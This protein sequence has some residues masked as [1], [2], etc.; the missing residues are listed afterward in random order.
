MEKDVRDVHPVGYLSAGKDRIVRVVGTN[1]EYVLQTIKIGEGFT[2]DMDDNSSEI[3]RYTEFDL[4]FL[5]V[6][7]AMMNLQ[8]TGV[9]WSKKYK[10][11]KKDF[12]SKY[13]G[14]MVIGGELWLWYATDNIDALDEKYTQIVTRLGRGEDISINDLLR[15]Q[16]P[17]SVSVNGVTYE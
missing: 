9:N 12:P 6:E 13:C 15:M 16:K 1:L 10:K 11:A 5:K 3:I 2:K 14:V 7:F 8:V 4:G 17:V